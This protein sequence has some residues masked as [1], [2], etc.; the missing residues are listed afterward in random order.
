MKKG[1]TLAEVL[2]TLAII[3]VVAAMTIPAM[4]HETNKNATIEQLKKSASTLNQAVYN[5]TIMEGTVNSWNWSGKDGVLYIMQKIISPR[6]SVGY[7]CSGDA[8]GTNS[9]CT[10][11]IKSIKG[12]EIA[13]QSFD[14]KTRV[15]L[16][17]G[18]LVAFSK[19][20]V[21]QSEVDDAQSDSSGDSNK[22]GSGCVWKGDPKALCG[23][24]MVDVNGN[25]TPNMIGKDVF[26]FGLYAS[27]S[28]L[29]Y[30]A[31]Q[32]EDFVERNCIEGSDGSTCAAKLAKNGW[33]VCYTGCNFPYP[34]KF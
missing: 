27:G 10:Y 28:V 19:G 2:M 6:L 3:G 30:G 7:M 25:K 32:G 29:P 26:F 31:P 34:V 33:E 4:I 23:I 13:D 14:V 12:E 11:P 16:N 21:T 9:Q 1:F 18:S 20:F 17:D 8:L 5:A 22:T 24:F 15:L